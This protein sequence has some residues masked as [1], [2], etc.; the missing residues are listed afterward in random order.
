MVIRFGI[1][2]S[3]PGQP[4]LKAKQ[5]FSLHNLLH[6]RKTGNPGADLIVFE[7]S[8]VVL[9]QIFALLTII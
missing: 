3:Y 7:F 8:V 2:L 4:L 9:K 1:H 6:N 5:L